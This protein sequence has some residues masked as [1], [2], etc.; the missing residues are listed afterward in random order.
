MVTLPKRATNLRGR[1]VG[2]LKVLQPTDKRFHRCVVWKCQCDCGN[3]VELSSMVLNNERVKSCGCLRAEMYRE[4]NSEFAKKAINTEHKYGTAVGK[5]QTKKPYSNNKSGY[6][7]I[8]WEK[9][10]NIWKAE[11]TFRGKRIY[12]G[13]FKELSDAVDAYE[14]A[15]EERVEAL[16]LLNKTTNLL[17]K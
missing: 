7:G 2:R 10:Y 14:T 13:R 17:Q 15:F 4:R 6:R 3:I 16:K 5:I 11:M 12:I 1:R 9:K 8:Y